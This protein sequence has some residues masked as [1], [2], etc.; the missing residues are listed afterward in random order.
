MIYDFFFPRTIFQQNILKLLFTLKMRNT[1]LFKFS[2]AKN[3]K[4]LKITIKNQ[5]CT[6]KLLTNHNYL[7]S[8]FILCIRTILELPEKSQNRT[9]TLKKLHNNPI[10]HVDK[11]FSF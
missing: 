9:I 6:K 1:A 8:S 2:M 10:H 5:F 4:H 3:L 7:S 11:S